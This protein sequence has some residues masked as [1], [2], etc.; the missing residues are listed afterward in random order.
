MC[1]SSNSKIWPIK[2]RSMAYISNIF[3]QSLSDCDLSKRFDDK[4]LRFVI[5]QIWALVGRVASSCYLDIK[6]SDHMSSLH[7]TAPSS[8]FLRMRLIL[9]MMLMRM[10]LRMHFKP[11]EMHQWLQIWQQLSDIDFKSDY[12]CR[13]SVQAMGN[14]SDVDRFSFIQSLNDQ[15]WPSF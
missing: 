13:T 3:N 5:V 7:S 14:I 4:Y 8:S 6:D 1:F 10:I 2:S 11:L 12:N 15:L 9:R